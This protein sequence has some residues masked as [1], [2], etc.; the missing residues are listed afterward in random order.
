MSPMPLKAKMFWR[1]QTF[2]TASL[3]QTVNLTSLEEAPGRERG[4]ELEAV[5]FVEDGLV[6]V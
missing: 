6:D 5:A 1:L 4:R 3:R 2:E